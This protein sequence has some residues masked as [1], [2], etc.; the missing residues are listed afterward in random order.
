MLK[1]ILNRGTYKLNGIAILLDLLALQQN[2]KYF[3]FGF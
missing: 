1:I 3:P 2:L